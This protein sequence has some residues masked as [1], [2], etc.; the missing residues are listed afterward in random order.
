MPAVS[1]SS[2]THFPCVGAKKGVNSQVSSSF[3]YLRSYCFPDGNSN[4]SRTA[5]HPGI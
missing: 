1:Q 4:Y 2:V 3:S 5:L